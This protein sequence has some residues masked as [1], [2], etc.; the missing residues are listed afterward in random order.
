MAQS[1]SEQMGE[2]MQVHIEAAPRPHRLKSRNTPRPPSAD[3][4]AAILRGLR[5]LGYA[6]SASSLCALI[7]NSLDARATSVEILL[8]VVGG[9]VERIAILDNGIGMPAEM[10]GAAAAVGST[11]QIADG[12]HRSRSGFGLPSAPLSVASRFDVYSRPRGAGL[13]ALRFDLCELADSRAAPQ[14]IAASALPQFVRLSPLALDRDDACGTIVV[15]SKLDR[16]SHPEPDALLQ[17]IRLRAGFAFGLSST[18]ITAQRVRVQ[19]I[20]PLFLARG[21]AGYSAGCALSGAVLTAAVSGSKVTLR[22]ASLRNASPARS[23]TAGERG[24]L[25]AAFP[26]LT[27][28][29]AGRRLATLGTTPVFDFAACPAVRAELDVPAELDHLLGASLSLQQV[30]IANRLWAALEQAGASAH[31]H[32]LHQQS[33]LQG[34]FQQRP[35]ATAELKTHRVP[36]RRNRCLK[37][38]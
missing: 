34:P 17:S 27:V 35:D 12:R 5:D 11:W 2:Q 7:D 14:A 32:A 6:D 10:L 37:G 9:R 15:L 1:L 13:A 31:L 24:R 26:G 38:E 29:R 28:S 36:R 22:T 16:L 3:I 33:L 20:D 30:R 21:A 8:D 4:G 23:A 18:R 19:P 25:A